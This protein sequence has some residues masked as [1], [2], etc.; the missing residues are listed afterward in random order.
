MNGVMTHI[1]RVSQGYDRPA[2]DLLR[3]NVFVVHIENRT[4]P[5]RRL[6]NLL[7]RILLVSS[8]SAKGHKPREIHRDMHGMYGDDCMDRSNVSR[9]CT[10]FQEGRVNL[11]DSPRSG[12]P[13][14]AAT[15]QNPTSS[16]RL[17]RY[18]VKG[19]LKIIEESDALET[20]QREEMRRSSEGSL[21][22]N[23]EVELVDCEHGVEDLC[24][25]LTNRIC[26]F[27]CEHGFLCFIL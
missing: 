8:E 20:M 3:K 2:M 27:C 25:Q 15:T 5:I 4:K 26:L 18:K 17:Y 1:N 19:K 12:Q 13:T 6:V 11:S 16:R 21:K 24:L 23:V 14:T 9:W 22:L 10:F 7:A